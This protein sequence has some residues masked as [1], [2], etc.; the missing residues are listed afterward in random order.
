M[1]LARTPS[2]S[3]SST[4]L[5]SLPNE[6]ILA[7]LRYF[8]H[9]CREGPRETPREDHATLDADAASWCYSDLSVLH[10]MS[11]VCRRFFSLAQEILYHQFLP[12]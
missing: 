10:S 11:L 9:H 4:S 12:G 6:L 3:S 5:G 2:S 7:I 8:C 1:E